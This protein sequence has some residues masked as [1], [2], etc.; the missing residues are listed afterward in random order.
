MQMAA[1]GGSGALLGD[2]KPSSLGIGAGFLWARGFAGGKLIALGKW[3]H[4]LAA[5]NRFE[6][7]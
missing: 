7:N 2:F 5:T 6:S 4:Q 1:G 3:L